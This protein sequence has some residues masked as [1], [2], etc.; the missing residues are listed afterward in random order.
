VLVNVVA[1]SVDVEDC[2]LVNVTSTTPIVGKAGLLYNVVHTSSSAELS[3]SE[4]RADVFMPNGVHHVMNSKLSIDGGKVWKQTLEGNPMSFEGIYK[5]NQPLDV[6]AC[7]KEA[8]AA[9]AAARKAM[10][11]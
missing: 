9:H 11:L 1:P 7:T 10:A 3:A 6:S 4:V 5:A 2:V 8:Q